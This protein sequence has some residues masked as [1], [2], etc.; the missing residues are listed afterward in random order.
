MRV[1]NLINSLCGISRSAVVPP[2]TETYS[3]GPSDAGVFLSHLSSP[4]SITKLLPPRRLTNAF[5]I[6]YS[7]FP[8]FP[9]LPV[10][11]TGPGVEIPKT[12]LGISLRAEDDVMPLISSFSNP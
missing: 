4:S 2:S 8:T 6:L 12:E 11:S 5:G 10:L 3:G 7:C 9:C 1:R